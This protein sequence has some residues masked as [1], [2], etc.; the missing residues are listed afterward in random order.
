MPGFLKE[1][2]YKEPTDPKHTP[3]GTMPSNP[4]HLPFFKRCKSNAQYGASFNGH[5][6]NWT[7]W[8]MPWTETY[9][10]TSRLLDGADLNSGPLLVDMGGHYGLDVE[11]LLKKHPD[12]PAGAVVLQDLP[13]IIAE[14]RDK[15]SDKVALQ[16][17]N[18]FEL[19]PM[20][21]SRAYFMH[22]ILH[23]W[24]DTVVSEIFAKLKP[25]MKRGYSKLLIVDV[26]IPPTGASVQ[27]AAMDVEVM[28]VL[29]G[30]ERTERDWMRMLTEAGFSNVRFH[31]DAR[32]YES[33]IEAELV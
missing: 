13:Q 25:T 27:Q 30:R 6:A 9:D 5:M 7:K 4:S 11:R 23:D 2:G 31:P 22:A 28:S 29:A 33:V 21:A 12:L 24:P 1:T 19:Q 8:K 26:V 32:G 15:V 10:T 16:E 17:H 18:F 20:L 3:Y 14:A